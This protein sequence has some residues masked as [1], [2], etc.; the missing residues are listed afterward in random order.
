MNIYRFSEH[1]A[2]SGVTAQ[3]AGER[4]EQL[5][6]AHEVLTPKLIVEDARSEE[7]ALHPIFEWDDSLAAE[8]HREQQA[9]G[10]MRS[11]RLIQVGEQ[12]CEPQ[13]VYLNV[14]TGTQRGYCTSARIMSDDVLRE[15]VLARAKDDLKAWR[16]RYAELQELADLFAI[17][18]QFTGSAASSPTEMA[19]KS[20]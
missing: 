4:L 16:V 7:A 19:A 8:Q 12:S 13:R 6:A 15:Q 3:I 9:R 20:Q 18:D 5:Q 17:V 14:S 2:P 1:G 11:I 10:L